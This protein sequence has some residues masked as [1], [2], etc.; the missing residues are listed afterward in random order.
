VVRRSLVVAGMLGLVGFVTSFG[1]HIIAKPILGA[2]AD[3]QGMK[4]AMLAG[5][6]LFIAT[7]LADPFVDPRLLILIRFLQGGGAAALSAIS[8]ALI[9]VCYHEHCGRAYDVYSAI[10]GPATSSARWWAARSCSKAPSPQSSSPPHWSARWRS[11]SR[12]RARTR[13][14]RQWARRAPSRNWATC[15]GRC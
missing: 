5:I 3:R 14:A 8:L 2:V 11:S 13:W 7:S 9:G 4:R 15:W 1:A 12:W 10:K 6:L